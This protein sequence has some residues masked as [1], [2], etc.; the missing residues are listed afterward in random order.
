[1]Q[2]IPLE[3]LRLASFEGAPD[4]RKTS[5]PD[6]AGI[7]DTLRSHYRPIYPFTVYHASAKS[8]RRY[9]LFTTTEAARKK[10]HDA[11][12]DA[13]AVREARQEGNMV[14]SLLISF[15]NQC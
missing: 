2:P 8:L 6:D 5:R 3:Y 13:L 11:L 12:L 9:T 1:M 7:L 10:W 4:S 14:G 15:M